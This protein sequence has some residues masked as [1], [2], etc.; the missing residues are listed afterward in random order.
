MFVAGISPLP[1]QDFLKHFSGVRPVH[2][3]PLP[4]PDGGHVV[5]ADRVLSHRFEA[6]GE[7]YTLPPGFSWKFNP[8]R[9]KEWQIAHHKFYF[10]MD[11]AQAWRATDD[12][13]YLL[14]WGELLDSWLGEMG[15]G[16]ITASDAQVEAKRL[17]HWIVSFLLLAGTRWPNHIDGNFLRRFVERIGAEAEYVAANLK[18]ARN[19]RT[20]QLYSIF[21]AGVIFPEFRRAPEFVEM[22]ARLLTENLLHDFGPD[23]VHIEL[24]SHYHNITLET[25]LSFLELARLNEIELDP[26][27]EGRLRQA[28]EFSL[29]MHWPDGEIPLVNDSDNGD[30]LPMLQLAAR[31]FEDPRLWWGGTRGSRGSPPG[32]PGRHFAEAGYFCL[33]NGWGTDAGTYESR[34]HVLF[35]CGPPG[36]GSHYHADLFSFCYHLNGKQLIVDPGRYTYSPEPDSEGIDWR[37]E[38]KSTAFHNTVTVD[39]LDQ[40]R[41]LSKSRNPPQGIERFDRSRHQRKRGPDVEILDKDWSL[42]RHTDWVWATARS[43]EYAPLH[44]RWFVFMRREYLF[45]L[46]LVRPTDEYEHEAA[47]RFHLAARWLGRVDFRDDG[48]SA[49]ALG[50]GWRVLT[51]LGGGARGILTHGSVSKTY[52]KKEAAPVIAV[53]RRCPGAQVFA[54]IIGPDGEGYRLSGLIRR[55]VGGT[56]ILEVQGEKDGIP[57]TDCFEARREAGETTAPGLRY[58]GPRI[59]Y[60]RGP[61]GNIRFGFAAC[62]EHLEIHGMHRR[63]SGG[64]GHAEW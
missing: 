41:Y 23:G 16:F 52:G 58:R 38:F 60:R 63:D 62:P 3:P 4:T 8:S 6:V 35:D 7:E 26:A 48:N 1:P 24:S 42:G 54:S 44:T 18:P 36:E 30:H 27:L 32:T 5:R 28:S 17:E 51:L 49:T 64:R 22:G 11:L 33:S 19:H 47:L 13:R 2:V 37:R 9:D 34:Q 59:G 56:E 12:P 20:F 25:A 14:R 29:Y 15:S 21:L 40:T 10:A 57:F 53:T 45:I 43:Q 50:E 31:L 55:N 61:N 39:G 46:D